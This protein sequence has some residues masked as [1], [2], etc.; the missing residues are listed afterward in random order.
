MPS[1]VP[2]QVSPAP[3]QAA[4][5]AA[6]APV[7]G[8]QAP[9]LAARLQASHCPPHEVLQQ[10]PSA[11][12]PLWHWW[13]RAQTVPS[14]CLGWQLVPSQKSPAMQL[15]SMVQLVGQAAPVPLQT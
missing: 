6:G 7:E 10:T 14:P 2:P 15:A 9:R 1:Q 12:K 11:Q 13:S 3:V 4:R 8:R 5:G